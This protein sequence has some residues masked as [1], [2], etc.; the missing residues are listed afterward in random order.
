MLLELL[1][2]YKKI[3]SL[4]QFERVLR[5]LGVH[6]EPADFEFI[7][8]EFIAIRNKIKKAAESRQFEASIDANKKYSESELQRMPVGEIRVI[9]TVHGV[10]KYKVDGK[11]KQPKPVLIQLLLAK[12]SQPGYVPFNPIPSGYPTNCLKKKAII[13]TLRVRNGKLPHHI[14]LNIVGKTLIDV[15]EPEILL[16]PDPAIQQMIRGLVSAEKFEERLDFE[17]K[18]SKAELVELNR[19]ELYN[20]ARPHGVYK[21]REGDS[22]DWWQDKSILVERLDHFFS[23]EFDK[24]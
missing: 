1:N 4:K 20:L 14:F 23:N 9:C 8:A 2:I 6:M 24:K 10:N 16:V 11:T 15:T 21:K 19:F 12:L 7:P 17:K 13:E 5:K 22:D 3:F 18:F